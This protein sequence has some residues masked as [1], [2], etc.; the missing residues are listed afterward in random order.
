MCIRDRPVLN[1]APPVPQRSPVPV[2]A[3]IAAGVLALLVVLLARRRA[4]D[5][6]RP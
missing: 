4:T 2:A 6:H 1:L 5:C 3:V